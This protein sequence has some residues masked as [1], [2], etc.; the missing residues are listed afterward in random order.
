MRLSLIAAVAR[1]RTIGA[2][3]RLPWRLPDDMAW[4]KRWTMGHHVVMG[5]KT[6]ESLRKPLVGRENMVLTRRPHYV[7]PGATTFSTLESAMAHAERAGETELMVIGGADVYAAALPLADRLYLTWIHHEVE[8]DREFPVL[9]GSWVE[10]SREEHPADAL[11]AFP[12]ALC[13]LERPACTGRQP[14]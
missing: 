12:F 1:N 3:G 11:H 2:D 9:E 10:C 6:W 7:A 8:G 4:F 5:R 14:A 13:V